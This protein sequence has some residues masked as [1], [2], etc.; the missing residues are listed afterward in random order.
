[1]AAPWSRP[2]MA[3]VEI[4]W[5]IQ[6]PPQELKVGVPWPWSH[7]LSG[8]SLFSCCFFFVQNNWWNLQGG[9]L[10]LVK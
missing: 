9:R 6:T 7:Y 8:F 10:W 4:P 1:M 5:V 3:G 2:H